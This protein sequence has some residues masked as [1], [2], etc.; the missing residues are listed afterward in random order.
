MNPLI[1]QRKEMFHMA[2]EEPAFAL[3]DPVPN[4]PKSM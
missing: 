3:A 2:V 1:A 4:Q